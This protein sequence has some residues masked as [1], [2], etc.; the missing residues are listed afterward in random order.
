MNTIHLR[1]VRRLF[2]HDMAPRHVQRHNMR[3]WVRS[4]RY[5]G[6]KWKG[7]PR[8]LTPMPKEST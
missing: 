5:L 7:I 1:R 2:V 3:A 4:V 8:P 6:D